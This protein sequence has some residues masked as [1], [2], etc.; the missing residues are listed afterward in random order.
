MGIRVAKLTVAV[1]TSIAACFV[2]FCILG[3]PVAAAYCTLL[4]QETETDAGKHCGAKNATDEASGVLTGG[5]AI[6]D[7]D[8]AVVTTVTDR[9][10]VSRDSQTLDFFFLAPARKHSATADSTVR[11]QL[12]AHALLGAPTLNL[13]LRI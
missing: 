1:N 8:A 13:P 4:C 12:S 10:V 5:V 2:I 6:C 7:H 3:Q 11:P 9:H